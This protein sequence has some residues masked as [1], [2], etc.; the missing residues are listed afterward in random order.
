VLKKLLETDEGALHLGEV[1]LVPHSSPV[2]KQEVIFYN[3]LF[4]ENASCHLALG[5]AYPINIE[6]GAKMTKEELEAKG[7]NTSMIH[8][9][10]M[11][12]SEQL[13]IKGETEDGVQEAI[14]TDGEWAI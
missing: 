6:G 7:I 4:D 14:M 10:F 3:T 1:A 12:G 13:S 2:S 11:I 9:D 8:V 5:S